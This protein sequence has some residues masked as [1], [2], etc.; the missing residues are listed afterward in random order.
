MAKVKKSQIG[1]T[2]ASE[3]ATLF[4][5]QEH[6][7]LFRA[8]AA[9]E[10][11]DITELARLMIDGQAQE[12]GLTPVAPTLPAPALEEDAIRRFNE[13]LKG[14]EGGNERLNLSLGADYIGLLAQIKTLERRSGSALMRLMIDKRAIA[15]GLQPVQVV[16]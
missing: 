14:A 11:R 10:R 13:I 8:M 2:Q 1:R 15:M 4:V 16:L 12:N 5:G 3:R 7:A 6:G 9:I